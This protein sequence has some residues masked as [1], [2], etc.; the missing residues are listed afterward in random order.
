MILHSGVYWYS[1]TVDFNISNISEVENEEGTVH[2]IY[3]S[4]LSV[5]WTF[6]SPRETIYMHQMYLL[7][8]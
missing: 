8:L 3:V 1:W 6:T 2:L 7:C 5:P 4:D